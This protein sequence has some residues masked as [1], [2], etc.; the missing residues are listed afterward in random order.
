MASQNISTMAQ[1]TMGNLQKACN[2]ADDTK[3]GNITLE[4]KS[5]IKG[6]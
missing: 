4:T 5:L 3:H 1:F 2:T 6:M